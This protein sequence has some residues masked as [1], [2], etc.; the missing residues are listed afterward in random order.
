MINKKRTWVTF[1]DY[2]SVDDP[3]PTEAPKPSTNPKPGSESP[4]ASAPNVVDQK[5]YGDVSRGVNYTAAVLGST[6][7]ALCFLVL[8][9]ICL[10]R[11][12]KGIAL[13][14]IMLL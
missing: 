10:C 5:K 9:I 1:R 3:K 4:K 14:N 8:C 7:A 2:A 13:L 6:A 12:C 11:K